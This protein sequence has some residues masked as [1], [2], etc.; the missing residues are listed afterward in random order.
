M[1]NVA[2]KVTELQEHTK[3][4]VKSGELQENEMNTEDRRNCNGDPEKN[5]AKPGL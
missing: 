4:G 2:G 3:R 5:V 1:V